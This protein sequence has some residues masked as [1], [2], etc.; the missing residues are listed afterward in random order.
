MPPNGNGIHSADRHELR[1]QEV[2]AQIEELL[3]GE[4]LP[5]E[6][7]L[8]D[9]D[10]G[11]AEVDDER[12]GG[13]GRILPDH[14]LGDRGDLGVRG[15]EARLRLQVDL[16]DGLP[17]D[18]GG[19]DA[20]D[21]VHRGG[22]HALVGGGDPPFQ[23]LGVEPAVLPGHRDD[24]DVDRGKDV[25]GRARDDDRTGDQDQESEDDEGVRPIQRDADDPHER[26]PSM[27]PVRPRVKGRVPV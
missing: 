7:E 11:R 10:A 1:P 3:L 2:D 17:V 25:G 20:L 15:V 14:G 13:A 4:A 18:G 12:R 5:R 27:R 24:R 22:E 26:G 16:D 21:V 23:L 6:R 8:Q 19:L 9:R